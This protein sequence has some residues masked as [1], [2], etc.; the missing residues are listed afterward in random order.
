MAEPPVRRVGIKMYIEYKAPSNINTKAITVKLNGN[1]MRVD[2]INERTLE[3]NVPGSYVKQGMNEVEISV[4]GSIS[5]PC[6]ISDLYVLIKY[7]E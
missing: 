1:I 3:N 5:S 6:I 4:E 7:S 2:I